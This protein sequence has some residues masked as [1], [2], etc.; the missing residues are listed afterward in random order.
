MG[1]PGNNSL[2]SLPTMDN[3]RESINPGRHPEG[4]TP[5]VRSNPDWNPALK[6]GL[7]AYSA[8]QYHDAYILF[9][10]ALDYSRE[11]GNRRQEAECMSHLGT[12]HRYNKD[13]PNARSHFSEAR[14]I[15]QT[16]GEGYLEE[17]LQCDR[18]LVQVDER[19]GDYRTALHAYESIRATAREKGFRKQE[20][21]CAYALGRLYN[22]INLYDRALEHLNEAIEVAQ[23]LQNL[24]IQAFAAEES[25]RSE[26]LRKNKAQ[27]RVYYKR[28][29]RL[30]HDIGGGR[31]TANEDRVRAK[32]ERVQSSKKLI[33][34]L[35]M[36]IFK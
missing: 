9:Q 34:C 14:S 3:R 2:G 18:Q 13:Y 21:W 16:L 25:G 12:L 29:L 23:N 30:F 20:A 24:E 4:P 6:N 7:S 35:P 1:T 31:Q 19:T 27:A 15:Y 10:V 11:T 28:A 22:V 8:G 33:F 26:E 36:C 32:L 17:Q 5:S